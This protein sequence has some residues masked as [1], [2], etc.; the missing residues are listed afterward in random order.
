[1]VSNALGSISEYLSYP[2]IRYAFIA[3]I[4]IALCSS[5]IGVILVLK[6]Y[7]FMGDGLSHV[8]FGALAVA[9]V[10]RVNNELIIVMPVTILCAILLL[11]TQR[12]S[13]IKGD[14]ALAMLSVGALAVG[15]LLMNIF[16]VSS[17]VSGDVCGTLFGSTSIL[18][19]SL[20]DVW[21]CVIMSAIVICLFVL[22]YNRIFAVTF[23]E[24]FASASGIS[25]GGYNT[26]ISV[27]CA[28][29]I[30]LAMNLAGSLL[31]SALI[32]FPAIS[33][34]RIFRGFKQV[35]ICSAVLSVICAALGIL[36]SIIFSTPVGCTVVAADIL[37]FVIFS[38]IGKIVR[39]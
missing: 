21:V 11:T 3:G 36:L 6:R 10:L 5:L 37:A 25:A 18:A 28:V 13:M 1:M 35:V 26:V 16:P 33:A 29:I 24:N 19:L 31:T 8:A 20:S 23:D 7:S 15:Y 14:S 39:G 38:V 34:M 30:V 32:V 2:F 4:L 22:M 27:V 12:R 17:N 9:T